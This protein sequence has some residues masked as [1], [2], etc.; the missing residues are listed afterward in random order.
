MSDKSRRRLLL[1]SNSRNYDSEYLEHA[2]GALRDFLGTAVRSVLFIPY[3]GVTIGWDEY[4]NRVGE[5]FS[6]LGYE[7]VSIHS[8]GDPVAAVGE[9]QAIA[10]GGGNTFHLLDTMSGNGTLDAIRDRAR[11]GTPYIG[12]SAGS[13]VACPTIRTTN[14]MPIVEPPGFAAL[15]L[16]PF[17]INPHYT[18][19]VLPHHR[20]ETRADRIA[21][22]TSVEDGMW[23]VGLR[24]GSILRVEGNEISLL[25]DRDMRV[26]RGDAAP[27]DVPPADDL[28]FLLGGS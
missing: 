23:V 7:L 4:A 22:F 27:R 15:G 26:F 20:G 9:A 12:W 14:D 2:G 1:L 13:N 16:V 28:A 18:D 6:A 5:R 11:E 24:E 19:A 10:V 25:G 3:A 21:E 8:Q 17:Q